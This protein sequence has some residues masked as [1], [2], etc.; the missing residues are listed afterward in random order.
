MIDVQACREAYQERAINDVGWV[1]SE[2][3]VDGGL[4]KL[5]RSELVQNVMR[6]GTLS[7]VADQ[8]VV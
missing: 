7:T 5:R 6:T 2:N 3:N 4:T 1:K 8:W